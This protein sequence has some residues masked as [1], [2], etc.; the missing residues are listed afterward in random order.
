MPFNLLPPALQTLDVFLLE[1]LFDEMPDVAFFVKDRE[2]RYLTVNTSL[3][4]R[5]GLKNKSQVMGKRPCDIST[6]D[7][8][9][10]P[11][12]QD[13]WVLRTARPLHDH[14]EMQWQTPNQPCWCL[15]T[16]LPILDKEGK[17][18]GLIG[19]SRDIRAPIKAQQ[20]PAALVSVLEHFER[21]LA[22]P[23]T[24]TTLAKSTGMSPLRFSRL[25]KRFFGITPSQ[26]IAKHRIT[27]ASVLLLETNQSVSDIALACGYYDHSA[28]TRAFRKFTGIAPTAYRE[29]ALRAGAVS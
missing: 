12:Q 26:Y 21:H 27:A 25:M 9:R 1:T 14:L 23:V 13:E 24:P 10:I 22:D 17:V 15:T 4:E 2:G 29:A 20:I 7:F 16:K 5:H 8:G 28:F 11:S 6:G 19:I 3:V 18:S